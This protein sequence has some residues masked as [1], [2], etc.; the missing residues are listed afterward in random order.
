MNSSKRENLLNLAL[1]ATEEERLQSLNLN[2]GYQEE[3]D[4]WE[5]I[6]KYTGSLRK[7]EE[8]FPDIEVTELSNEYAVIRLPEA[9]MDAVTD[10]TEI[11]YMEK[12]KRLFF[13]VQQGIRASCLTSLYTRKMGLGGTGLSGK[14]VITAFLDSGERVIIMSS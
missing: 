14:G 11:E 9:L 2:V 13:S 6:V 7:L 5:V 8:I 4:T 10:R 3:T 1:D 12:P